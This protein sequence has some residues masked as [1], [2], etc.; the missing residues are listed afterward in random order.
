MREVL[1]TSSITSF[2]RWGLGQELKFL[3]D[4]GRNPE[5]LEI[6]SRYRYM[7]PAEFP[8]EFDM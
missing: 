2:T 4:T 5:K 7:M 1:K 3:W 8:D 6:R